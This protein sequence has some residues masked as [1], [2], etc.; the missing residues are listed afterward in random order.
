MTSLLTATKL[1]QLQTATASALDRC[2]G[3][4]AEVG[5]YRGGSAKAMLEV[6]SYLCKCRI[7]HLFDTFS[8]LPEPGPRDAPGKCRAGQW[9]ADVPV[10]SL[11]RWADRVRF[12]VGLFPGTAVGLEDERFA[13]VHVD[14][15]LEES[16]R[17]CCEWF[18]SRM[19]R[20]G[21]IVFDDYGSKD[22]RG[23]KPVV[24]SFFGRRVKQVSKACQAEVWF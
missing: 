8:G 20:G 9:A 13:V 5:V 17:A 3:S 11:A 15:D 4:M 7:M 19:E 1:E 24:D 10:V 16:V 23:V 2:Y 21:I 18:G 12:H 22:W 6:M 14:V